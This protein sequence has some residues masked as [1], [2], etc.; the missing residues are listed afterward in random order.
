MLLETNFITQKTIFFLAKVS[1]SSFK[2]SIW[3]LNQISD[4]FRTSYALKLDKMEAIRK[5]FS[6]QSNKKM[7][8]WKTCSSSPLKNNFVYYIWIEIIKL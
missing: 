5:A 4:S 8:E 1:N 2:R 6:E 3:K 7:Y